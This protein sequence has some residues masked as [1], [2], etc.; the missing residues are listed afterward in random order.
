MRYWLI[1]STLNMQVVL[2]ETKPS[3]RNQT[4]KISLRLRQTDQIRTKSVFLP[5]SA[6][7]LHVST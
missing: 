7:S 5:T 4:L 1:H 6:L 2:K 3:F